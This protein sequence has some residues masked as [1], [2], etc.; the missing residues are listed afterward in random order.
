MI[1]WLS[2]QE[3]VFSF[4][5]YVEVQLPTP[6]FPSG[7]R[8]PPISIAKYPNH[9]NKLISLIESTH[10]A[11]GL[12]KYLKEFL[13]T[14]LTDNRTSNRQAYSFDLPF[15]HL[16]VYNMFKFHPVSLTDDSD[17]NDIVKAIPC[18]SKLPNGRFDTVVVINSPEAEATGLLGMYK[19]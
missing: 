7:H 8:K 10:K 11:P 2:R 13:N 4:N 19:L 3:K 12:T 9:P 5:R 18:S 15:Q 16:N 14:F 17:A 1:R 6:S